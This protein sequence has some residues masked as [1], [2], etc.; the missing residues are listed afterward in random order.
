MTTKVDDGESIYH[1]T[2]AATAKATVEHF[3]I[4]RT[5]GWWGEAVH[6]HYW[7]RTFGDSPS[8]CVRSFWI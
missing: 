3:S 8:D 6:I 1:A 7:A 5:R 2:V 4:H